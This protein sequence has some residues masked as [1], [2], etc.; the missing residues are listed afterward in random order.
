[1][2]TAIW[3]NNRTGKIDFPFILMLGF[4]VLMMGFG[5][6]TAA[7][8]VFNKPAKMA[9]LALQAQQI[10][11]CAASGGYVMYVEAHDEGG[12]KPVKRADGSVVCEAR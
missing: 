10:E 6:Y 11:A 1:M 8:S 4:I 7:Q 5:F 9:R 2:T 3:K 12:M